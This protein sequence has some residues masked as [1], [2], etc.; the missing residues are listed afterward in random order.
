MAVEASGLV[1]WGALTYYSAKSL[2]G[3]SDDETVR[4]LGGWVMDSNGASEPRLCK[5]HDADSNGYSWVV[6]PE[7]LHREIYL[8]TN[9]TTSKPAMCQR[10]APQ[11]QALRATATPQLSKNVSACALDVPGLRKRLPIRGLAL[12][13]HL[14]LS[15]CKGPTVETASGEVGVNVLQSPSGDEVTRVGYSFASQ[16]LFVE[17]A[18]S[19]KL[20]AARPGGGVLNATGKQGYGVRTREVAPLPEVKVEGALRLVLLLDQSILTVFANDAVV[21]TTRVYTAG[22]N[23]SADVSFF[24]EGGRGGGAGGAPRVEGSVTGWP[25]SL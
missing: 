25:L 19:S 5:N 1:D 3:P 9:S 18:T 21:I 11:L 23:A 4:L 12:E 2:A 22:G 24:A 6:C 10:P 17:R 20:P 13:I 14:N 7:A 15:F 8:C 16:T